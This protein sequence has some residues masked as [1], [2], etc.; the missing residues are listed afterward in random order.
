MNIL[1]IINAK[2]IIWLADN[3]IGK[4]PWWIAF[5]AIVWSVYSM[6][7]YIEQPLDKE[8]TLKTMHDHFNALNVHGTDLEP[9]HT[10]TVMHLD[11]VSKVSDGE[12]Y[13][14]AGS[15]IGAEE[16]YSAWHEIEMPKYVS[17]EYGYRNNI[18]WQ[19]I[20][21]NF[22][23]TI[24]RN[25]DISITRFEYAEG[26]LLVG[27]VISDPD[28]TGTEHSSDDGHSHS[29]VTKCKPSKWVWK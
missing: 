29:K 13:K 8:L 6:P 23:P 14:G 10:V 22:F 19:V 9:T 5:A 20:N 21:A 26:F 25:S 11:K 27:C 17:I 2:N 18:G 4:L 24:L 1:N 15:L 28:H 7:S 16:S 12:Y 3:T